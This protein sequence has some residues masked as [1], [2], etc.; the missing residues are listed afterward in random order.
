MLEMQ[1][2]FNGRRSFKLIYLLYTRV[3]ARQRLTIA[4]LFMNRRHQSQTKST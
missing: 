1:P 2:H 3:T 4:T